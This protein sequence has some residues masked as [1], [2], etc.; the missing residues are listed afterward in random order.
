MG[1]FVVVREIR[2]GDKKPTGPRNLRL[3]ILI[4]KKLIE[5]KYPM[6]SI[7]PRSLQ[8]SASIQGI[9]MSLGHC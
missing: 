2:F 1:G 8:W 7:G 4:L 9:G 6:G 5:S 3:Y